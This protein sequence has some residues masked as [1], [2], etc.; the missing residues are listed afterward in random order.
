MYHLHD[1]E[2]LQGNA[3]KITLGL[4]SKKKHL[5]LGNWGYAAEKKNSNGHEKVSYLKN[6]SKK[7]LLKGI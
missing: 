3:L 2:I 6:I 5:P 7:K 4:E 1:E